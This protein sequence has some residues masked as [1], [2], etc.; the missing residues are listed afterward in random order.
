MKIAALA[1]ERG[2]HEQ[3]S[4]QDVRS[5]KI[6]VTQSLSQRKIP[7]CKGSFARIVPRH[8]DHA[9][10]VLQLAE[11]PQELAA[12]YDQSFSFL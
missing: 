4:G 3:F 1:K 7:G 10:A 12:R 8:M 2:Y 9:I 5:P 11:N 6:L